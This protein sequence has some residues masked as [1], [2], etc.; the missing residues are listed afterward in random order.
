MKFVPSPGPGSP[1]TFVPSST[2]LLSDSPQDPA[3]Y[4]RQG[5]KQ[6]RDTVDGCRANARFDIAQAAN[7][8]S[9]NA[10]LK[11]EHSAASWTERADLL[12][13]IDDIHSRRLGAAAT[14]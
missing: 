4:V 7:M 12:Q 1:A 10:R 11:Y 5:S 14:T 8:T 13:R 6:V 9:G 2:P 3:P